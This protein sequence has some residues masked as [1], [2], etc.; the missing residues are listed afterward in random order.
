[1]NT[2]RLIIGIS[3]IAG[4]IFGSCKHA[5]RSKLGATGGEEGNGGVVLKCVEP[6]GRETYQAL[7]TYI[8]KEQYM[9]E[10]RGFEVDLYKHKNFHEKIDLA[11][12]STR[13]GKFSPVRAKR[14]KNTIDLF[15]KK[16]NFLSNRKIIRRVDISV[17]IPK[18]CDPRYII[19]RRKPQLPGETLFQIDKDIWDKLDED[20]KAIIALH[21]AVYEEAHTEY[22]H[23]TARYVHFFVANLISKKLENMDSHLDFANLLK[24]SNFTFFEYVN[25]DNRL[26]FLVDSVSFYDNGKLKEGMF[27]CRKNVRGEIRPNSYWLE[28]CEDQ[29]INFQGNWRNVFIG[30]DF[31]K[32]H[33]YENGGLKHGRL[34]QVE[35]YSKVSFWEVPFNIYLDNETIAMDGKNIKIR[36]LYENPKNRIVK[37]LFVFEPSKFRDSNY[38]VSVGQLIELHKN[39]NLAYITILCSP[40][41]F[42]TRSGKIIKF[43]KLVRTHAQYNIYGGGIY[44]DEEG[45]LISVNG[46]KVE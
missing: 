7:E 31:S 45:F 24:K 21:E 5:E 15:L 33:F 18:N 16:E 2:S 46:K 11:L 35:A 12:G 42:K 3:L 28:L 29:Q 43:E 34:H 4:V 14:Y 19:S 13:L 30:Y 20:N 25:T 9:K 10:D 39:G 41:S 44:L 17:A 32:T 6:D 36:E 8:I 40:G 38:E 37:S 26:S 23:N 27:Y 1:M 22:G